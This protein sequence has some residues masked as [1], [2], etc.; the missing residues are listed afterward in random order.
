MKKYKKNI[1]NINELQVPIL[2]LFFLFFFFSCYLNF[3]ELEPRFD[4]IRHISWLSNIINSNHFIHFNN[5]FPFFNNDEGGFLF[6]LLRVIGNSGDYHAYLFQINS[7]IIIYIFSFF[8]KNDLIFVY[9]F[10]SI[11]FSS[12]TLFLCYYLSNSIL[13]SL[14]IRINKSLIA[15][16]TCLLF[17]SYYKYYYSSLG[18]HNISNFFFILTII[19]FHKILYENK[20]KLKNYFFIGCIVTFAGYFQITNAI[21][22]IPSFGAYLLL[23]KTLKN[24]DILKK[25]ILYSLGVF[26]LLTPFF[27]IIIFTLLIGK[28][29]SFDFLLGREFNYNVFPKKIFNWFFHLIDLNGHIVIISIA[30]LLFNISSFKSRIINILLTVILI[31]FILNIVLNIIEISYIRS[32]LYIHHI[33]I[34]LSTVFFYK[35]FI[36]I[37]S[38]YIKLILILILTLNSYSN[39]NLILNIKELFK[40]ESFFYNFYYNKQGELKRTI[41]YIT[42]SNLINKNHDIIFFNQLTIDYFKIYSPSI[43]Y[44]SKNYNL[45]SMKEYSENSDSFSKKKIYRFGII[46]FNHYIISIEEDPSIIIS[47]FNDLKLKKLI[48]TKCNIEYPLFQKEILPNDYS[49]DFKKKLIINKINCKT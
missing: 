20:A 19:I 37:K 30:V 35:Y 5:Y 38:L 27:L 9:N 31:H 13:F 43:H 29:Y 25:T 14:K 12:L 16:I 23:D 17:F 39:F 47:T 7:I 44:L 10:T 24:W 40:K 11:L 28:N 21:L 8:I 45:L 49:G 32:Y 1:V 26:L 34:I 15:I 2:I 46:N 22:L 41:K 3:I 42:E 6:E 48:D 33:F 36:T 18:N 4:Q